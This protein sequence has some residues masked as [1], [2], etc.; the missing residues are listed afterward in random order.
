MYIYI[1]IDLYIDLYRCVS[2][3]LRIYIDPYKDLDVFNYKDAISVGFDPKIHLKKIGEKALIF[4][5]MYIYIYIYIDLYIDLYRCVS[6]LL[7]IYI[8]PYKDLDILN[9]TDAISVGFDPKIHLKKIGEKTF[10]YIYV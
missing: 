5:Y 10:I 3:L 9:Y 4:I 6:I 2:I 7:P 1:Y 8:D